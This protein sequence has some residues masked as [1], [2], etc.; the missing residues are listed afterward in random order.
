[1][2]I[3]DDIPT[4]YMCGWRIRSLGNEHYLACPCVHSFDGYRCQSCIDSD[5]PLTK[6]QV[7]LLRWRQ[8]RWN[9]VGVSSSNGRVYP[10]NTEDKPVGALDAYWPIF[11]EEAEKALTA[12]MAEGWKY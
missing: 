2:A 1:M 6:A 3:R 7:V 10:C 11:S 4:L 12:S 5:I 8:D 9:T